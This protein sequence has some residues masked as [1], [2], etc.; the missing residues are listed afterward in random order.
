MVPEDR[1]S[2]G[3]MRCSREAADLPAAR[4]YEAN[5]GSARMSRPRRCE[6]SRRTAMRR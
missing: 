3:A 5:T 2:P 6:L 4:W 1:Q